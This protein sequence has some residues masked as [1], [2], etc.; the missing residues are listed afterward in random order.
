[1]VGDRSR[2]RREERGVGPC[3]HLQNLLASE[4]AAILEFGNIGADIIVYRLSE[5]ADH[6]RIG[7]G[8]GLAGMID[9][10]AEPDA[11]LLEGFAPYRVLDGF[12]RFDEAS[13]RRV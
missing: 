7:E 10:A 8:P 12:A 13:K 5:A 6:Q 3:Q 11:R 2:R 9:D 4:P 1:M